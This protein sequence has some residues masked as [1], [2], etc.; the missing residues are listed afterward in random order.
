MH[1]SYFNINLRILNTIL[2]LISF[3]GSL[4]LLRK[5][6]KDIIANIHSSPKFTDF[7]EFY[8]FEDNSIYRRDVIQ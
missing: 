7:T 2:Y 6:N 1:T 8:C 4:L 5:Y 3:Y